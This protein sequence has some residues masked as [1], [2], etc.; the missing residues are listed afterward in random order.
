MNFDF[1]NCLELYL[2]HDEVCLVD[3]NVGAADANFSQAAQHFQSV[4]V[5]TTANN[6]HLKF[7]AVTEQLGQHTQQQ[8]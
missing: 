8:R 1:T 7:L 4:V 2:G 5:R 6:H 3:Q